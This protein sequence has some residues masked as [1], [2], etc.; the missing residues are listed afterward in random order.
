[1]AISP[2]PPVSTSPIGRV[3]SDLRALRAV[4][5][6]YPPGRH[7]FSMARTLRFNRDPL[8]MLL[9]A[10]AEFGPVFTLKLLY[11]PV[12]FMI[13]PDANHFMTVSGAK[14]FRWR[15]G[16][17]GDLI[18]LLGDGLLTI[19][20]DYH[21]WSRQ[22]MLPAFHR[23]RIAAA[24]GT[25]LDEAETAIA[26]WRPGATLDLYTWTRALALRV[27]MRALL[28]LDPDRAQ[29]DDLDAAHEFERALSY[30]GYD[31]VLQMLR[32][33][34]TPF[35]KLVD[36]RRK[37]DRLIYT[38]IARRRALPADARGADVMSLLLDAHDEE[39]TGLDDHQ[40]RD[41]VMTL[42]FAGHD[43]T[44]STVTF[45][46]HELAHAPHVLARLLEEQDRVLG[47]RRATAAELTTGLPELDMAV[48]ETLRLYPAAWIGPRR[49]AETFELAG[50]QVPRG[51]H[52]NYSSWVSHRLPEVFP[53][54]DAFIPERFAP[55]ARAAL[56][57]GAYVPFGGGS[58]M[59]L[60]MRFGELE[61]KAIATT[62]LQR[63]RLELVPGRTLVI[64]HAPTLSPKG[65]LPV[66]VR[67]RG[68]PAPVA[69]R[70]A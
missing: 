31:Y 59:C 25:M 60:G 68:V 11:M 43:T 19:D 55:E 28:G 51:A 15:D 56:P 45:L 41:Q 39:G 16:S 27:A 10:Y 64:R 38:E 14:S 62:I 21:R 13:G 36:A 54:P 48:A 2:P 5:V 35:A 46:F 44:T 20:G 50:V 26:G 23:E 34:G 4:P 8:P 6:P 40:M 12:V 1:M 37:L 42:L 7:D 9:E 66:V 22:I 49:A 57:K 18:P 67:E 3:V 61:I 24:A 58:R 70:A 32:G 69:A 53:E 52:V 33:P 63:F 30:H 47:G 65:G 17:L 29:G